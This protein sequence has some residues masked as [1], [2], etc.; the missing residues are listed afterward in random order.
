[1]DGK[2]D[3]FEQA[4][5][6][7]IAAVGANEAGKALIYTLHRSTEDPNLFLFYEQ[8]QGADAL[9]AH[10]TTDHMK[11][12]GGKLRGLLDGRPVIERYESL[13]GIDA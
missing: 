8:Y 3:E 7:Q 5:R 9:A 6:E 10:G 11:A 12:F 1:V 2:A 4:A 13:A